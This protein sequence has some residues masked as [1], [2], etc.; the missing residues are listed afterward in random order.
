ML[1]E[2][3]RCR[4][5]SDSEE[6][7]AV[8]QRAWRATLSAARVTPSKILLPKTRP[9]APATAGA[10]P[11]FQ[12][13]S[14]RKLSE[15]SLSARERSPETSPRAEDPREEEAF[16][17]SPQSSV[18]GAAAA[19]AGLAEQLKRVK[20]AG[21]S[22][23]RSGTGT[24]Q[25]PRFKRSGD[26]SPPP[27]PPPSPARSLLTR[28]AAAGEARVSSAALTSADENA[29]VSFSSPRPTPSP[30][31]PIRI[32]RRAHENGVATSAP[33]PASRNGV[34]TSAHEKE[35]TA[36]V[37]R[38]LDAPR[39]R[40]GKKKTRREFSAPSAPSAP[41][42][43]APS[44]RGV[45]GKRKRLSVETAAFA[46]RAATTFPKR[47]DVDSSS[48]K[49]KEPSAKTTRKTRGA[50]DDDE[51]KS[52]R[53]TN[54]VAYNRVMGNRRSA[55]NSKKRREALLEGLRTEIAR[56]RTENAALLAR[57]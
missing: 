39:S 8:R 54:P 6:A 20:R 57:K 12:D 42:L 43:S 3:A 7:P 30:R 10:R 47:G 5:D 55:A 48:E 27:A 38:R 33:T 31:T 22:R 15:P 23:A 32:L 19:L 17:S 46:A 21:T 18:G 26:A 11:A 14:A 35:R 37:R 28:V 29:P 16:F 9:P 25:S 1:L 49:E 13:V 41:S 34:A 51:L 50:Y 53:E 52:L 44:A 24:R 45:S 2:V 36:S 56:L 40:S 4:A